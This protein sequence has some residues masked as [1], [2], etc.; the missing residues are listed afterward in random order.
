M[1]WSKSVSVNDFDKYEIK[2]KI[3]KQR[4]LEDIWMD[5]IYQELGGQCHVIRDQCG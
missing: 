1:E 3:F 5:E 2:Y 4:N